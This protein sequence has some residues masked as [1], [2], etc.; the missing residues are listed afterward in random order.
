[1][2]AA[3]KTKLCVTLTV[4][5]AVLGEQ[6]QRV[7]WAGQRKRLVAWSHLSS[8]Q[9]APRWSGERGEEGH[10]GRWTPSKRM[11]CERWERRWGWCEGSGVSGDRFASGD[12]PIHLSLTLT[13]EARGEQ[14]ACGQG[15]YDPNPPPTPNLQI[16]T[17]S[18][19][20]THGE[21][22]GLGGE[23]I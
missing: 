19:K 1:M 4:E 7:T 6:W 3:G 8:P 12:S 5:V 2:L 15:K 23:V 17:V 9:I 10:N 22:T 14:S 21:S 13:P 18:Q 11:F 20:H 16:H